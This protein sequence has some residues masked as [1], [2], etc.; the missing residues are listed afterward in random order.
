MA[1]KSSIAKQE[2]RVKMVSAKWAKR[3]D[4]KKIIIDPNRTEEE[5]MEAVQKLNK[6][7]RNSSAVRLRNRCRMTGRCRGYIRKYQLSRLC[8]RELAS[9]GYIPGIMKASW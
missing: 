7:P 9:S 4:L 6:M 2:R 1:R 8:F 5:K 3:Q